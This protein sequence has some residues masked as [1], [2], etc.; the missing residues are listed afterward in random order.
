[1]DT[2]QPCPKKLQ[3]GVIASIVIAALGLV[4]FLFGFLPLDAIELVGRGII[5]GGMIV[6][7][8]GLCGAYCSIP[9]MFR[10]KGFPRL[11]AAL[12]ALVSL[13]AV[14]HCAGFYRWAVGLP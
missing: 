3:V 14:L 9:S 6:F 4:E 13:Y 10:L 1:M 8:A 5:I 2:T 11:V 12:S 7:V